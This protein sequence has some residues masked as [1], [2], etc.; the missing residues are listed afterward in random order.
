[1]AS[2][3]FTKLYHSNYTALYHFAR[4]L[5]RDEN[6]AEDLVQETAIKAFKGFHTFKSG[7]NFKS[8]AFTILKNLFITNY[9]KA[10]R[11]KVSNKPIE[12]FSFAIENRFNVKNEAISKLRIDEISACI[13][14]LSYKSRIPFLMMVNGYK[15][16]EI[17]D[18]LGIPTGTVKSRI[19]FARQKLQSSLYNKGILKA[20]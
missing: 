5:T 20:K 4:K 16:E 7:S 8:W 1:M 2:T 17:A 15:Y 13:E 6:K 3:Q 9:R 10:K 11:E 19:N 18:S 14:D 12:D